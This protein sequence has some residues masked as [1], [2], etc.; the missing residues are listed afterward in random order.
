MNALYAAIEAAK[1]V[2][3]RPSIIKLSTIMAWPSPTKQGTGAAGAALGADEVAGLEVLGLDPEKS[4]DVADDVIAHSHRLRITLRQPGE[5]DKQI[6]A[7][8]EANP[9]R[10]ALLNRL[11]AKE[12]PEGWDDV[13]PTFE[14]G[15][16]IATRAASVECCRRL[17]RC[18]RSCG[19]VPP[20]SQARTTPR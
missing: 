18:C 16:S 12:L 7:W 6:A 17:P 1:T 3:D 2:T 9:E 15:K 8:R 13:L 10:S 11:V 5:W 19:A 14:V 20:I 4:F